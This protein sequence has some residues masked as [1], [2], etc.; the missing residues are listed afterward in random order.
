VTAARAFPW[1]SLDSTTRAEVRALREVRD[2]A[3][4]H[5]ALGQV[6]RILGELL[7]TDVEV[8]IRGA[9]PLAHPRGLEGGAGVML[10]RADTP[11]VE[12]AVLI[13]AERALVAATLARVTR[14]PARVLDSGTH[15]SSGGA[16]ALAAI[17][18]AAARRA[19]DGMALRVLA[20]GPA[21]VL[22][23][24]LVR[25]GH[26]VSAVALTMIVGGEAFAARVVVPRSA[27][28]AAPRR[29]WTAVTLA[30]LGAIP[31]ELPLVARVA[32]M[33]VAEVGRLRAG[34]V[35]LVGPWPLQRTATG[36]A[37]PV[38]L[39]APDAAVGFPATLGQDGRLVLTGGLE[40]LGAAEAAMDN[41]EADKGELVDAIGD[42]PVVVRVEIGEARMAARDWALLGRGDVIALGRR[43]GE[44]VVLR[45]SSV[46]V[47]RGDLVEI[48]GEIGVRIVERLGEDGR[49]S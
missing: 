37:G 16:G 39:A 26:D 27:F 13:E 29:P 24:D 44:R 7:E 33:T 36:L 15:M 35:L 41:E 14:R 38:M 23:A 43:V 46:P 9:Q 1:G 45:V 31:L 12:H 17:V 3:R 5:V 32:D 47:A 8:L 28:L 25:L 42:V 22:E 11:R 6:P 2:W 30:A 18:A 48:D 34:D 40:P 49:S 20:A 21:P 19:H 10:A 4:G